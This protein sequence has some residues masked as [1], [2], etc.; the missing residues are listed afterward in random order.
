MHIFRRDFSLF[1]VPPGETASDPLP[2][3]QNYDDSEQK[4]T[5]ADALNYEKEILRREGDSNKEY[6]YF[7][8]CHSI[9]INE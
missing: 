7:K 5:L 1:L 2:L 8:I 6:M 9:V 3:R 4:R